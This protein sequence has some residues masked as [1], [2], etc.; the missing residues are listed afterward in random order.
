[1][2]L[3]LL[4]NIFRTQTNNIT[5]FLYKLLL[6]NVNPNP[7]KRSSINDTLNEMYNIYSCENAKIDEIVKLFDGIDVNT[8]T[9]IRA[10]VKDENHFNSIVESLESRSMMNK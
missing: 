7:D 10:F 5:L 4:F 8:V 2:Y 6:K 9:V 1:M 3:K